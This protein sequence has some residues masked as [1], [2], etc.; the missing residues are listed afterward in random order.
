M[1]REHG[2]TLALAWV[3]ASRPGRRGHGPGRRLLYPA[4]IWLRESN[5]NQLQ[6]AL[7]Q[8]VLMQIVLLH[9]ASMRAAEREVGCR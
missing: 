5:A 8:I 1:Y 4:G 6:I 9:C 2:D 3:P 7:M